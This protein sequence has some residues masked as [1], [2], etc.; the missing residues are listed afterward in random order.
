MR[1][2]GIIILLVLCLTLLLL[3]G[4]MINR[5]TPEIAS[6]NL[7]NQG[8]NNQ[9]SNNP[10]GSSTGSVEEPVIEDTEEPAEEPGTV[11]PQKWATGDGT[12]ENPWA[13]GCIKSAYNN[14][15]EG[16]TIYLMAGYYQLTGAFAITKSI[17]V[18]GEGRD[19]TIIVTDDTD[20]IHVVANHVT[21]KGFTIDGDAQP[22]G[23]Y[24]CFNLRGDYFVLE[25][26][27]VKNA[28][29]YGICTMDSDYGL[30]QNI[31][32]HNNGTVGFHP[33]SDTP[34]KG[35]Y[36]TY[37]NI[38]VWDNGAHGFATREG[39]GDPEFPRHNVYDNIH[40]WDNANA[41]IA[42][43]YSKDCVLSNSSSSGGAFG[44]YFDEVEDFTVSNCSVI[45]SE[46]HGVYLNE[47]T[48]VYFT[49]VT[50]KN[51]NTTDVAYKSGFFIDDCDSVVFTSCQSYDDRATPL[52]AYGIEVT[53]ANTNISLVNCKLT[54]NKEGE[55]Y[56]PSGTVVTVITEKKKLSKF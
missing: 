1:Y 44:L 30:Y 28:G 4:C 35:K 47:S 54:P 13:N 5:V 24:S 21:F 34:T 32:V 16:G 10:Q 43:T 42:I 2:S 14:V 36:N 50:S 56:N 12:V 6:G 3:T 18:I 49:N 40:A 51:N 9:S 39:E 37:R 26:I 8:G 48:N 11:Y 20:G 25:D 52:Q 17:N 15:P 23:R 22:D 27:E 31:Y 33:A 19:K 46:G 29:D 38:Y 45:L 53:G 55:I 7:E 41:G